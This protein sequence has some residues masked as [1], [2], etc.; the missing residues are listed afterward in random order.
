MQAH[1]TLIQCPVN[2]HHFIPMASLE[3]HKQKCRYAVLGV[4]SDIEVTR[5]IESIS[6][7]VA[8]LWFPRIQLGVARLGL[9]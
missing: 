8:S 2:E 3:E 5:Y 4:Q 6:L 1:P 7:L 9:L